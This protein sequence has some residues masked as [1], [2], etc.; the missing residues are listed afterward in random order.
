MSPRPTREQTQRQ[1][2]ARLLAAAAE[3]IA[4][5]GV[6]GTSIE[7]I[8][9]RAGYSRGAFY[10]NFKDKYDLVLELLLDQTRQGI[11]EVSALDHST[12][13]PLRQY[14]R[15]RAPH[16]TSWLTLRM[17]LFLHVLRH[18][19]LRPRLAEREHLARTALQAGIEHHFASTGRTPPA[20]PAQ[21]ALIVHALEDGLL[22]Q[23]SLTPDELPDDLAVDAYLLLIRSWTALSD[24][25]NP[26]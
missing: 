21:L 23:K 9:D 13:E 25:E 11:D 7:Q 17:E 19:E 2:R 15:D 6:N 18:P 10:S 12:L 20:D 3:L 8:A 5:H 1:T 16:I 14:N 4:D 22:I 24:K 26:T